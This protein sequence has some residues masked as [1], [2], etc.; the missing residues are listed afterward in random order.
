MGRAGE[1]RG[2]EEKEEEKER[3]MRRER[4]N[5]ETWWGGVVRVGSRAKCLE[6]KRRHYKGAH[7]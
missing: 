5:P 1:E 6:K 4:K 3:I 7:S 2:E